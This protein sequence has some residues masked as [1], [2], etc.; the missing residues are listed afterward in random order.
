[1]N[2]LVKKTKKTKTKSIQLFR[3][4]CTVQHNLR[5]FSQFLLVFERVTYVLNMSINITSMPQSK[6]IIE[7]LQLPGREREKY[8]KIL[9]RN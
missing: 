8:V 7:I 5:E 1:M 6:I 9:L 4:V 3:I 2:N